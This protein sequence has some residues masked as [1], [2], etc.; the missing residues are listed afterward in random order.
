V[1]KLGS[2]SLVGNI[3]WWQVQVVPNVPVMAKTECPS[4][5]RVPMDNMTLLA[6]LT[7]ISCACKYRHGLPWLALPRDQNKY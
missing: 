7:L 1:I 5:A 2:L 4:E 6:H 3:S